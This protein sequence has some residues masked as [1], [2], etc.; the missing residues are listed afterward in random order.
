MVYDAVQQKAVS[1]FAV[2]LGFAVLVILDDRATN[3]FPG[4]FSINQEVE[5]IPAAQA[6]EHGVCA[7]NRTD[8]GGLWKMS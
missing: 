7:T 3:A 5:V 6:R 1:P 4:V 8:F 2:A